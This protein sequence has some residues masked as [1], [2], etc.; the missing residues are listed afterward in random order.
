MKRKPR[1]SI[2]LVGLLAMSL[3]R[4]AGAERTFTW[5]NPLPFQHTEGQAAPRQEVRDPCILH[6]GDTYYLVFTMWPFANREEKRMELLNNDSSPG[7]A[8]YSSPD[9]QR[10]KF[11]DWL[12]RSSVLLEGSPHK[13]RFW[14]PEIHKLGG[15]LYLIFTADK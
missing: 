7:I 8:L 6:E 10:W 1:N 4:A 12:V 9:L 2:V 14:E 5:S 13:H 15:R 3:A 11:E